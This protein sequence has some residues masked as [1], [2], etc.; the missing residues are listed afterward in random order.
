MPNWCSNTITITADKDTINALWETL[1]NN[2]DD[3]GEGAQPM[4]LLPMP[5][6]LE[7]TQSPVPKPGP[8]DPNGVLRAFVDDETN[9]HWTEA[10]YADRKAEHERLTNKAAEALAETGYSEWYS[11]CTDNWG[12]K[13]PMNV[14]NYELLSATEISVRGDTAWGPPTELLRKVSEIHPGV[15]IYNTFYEEGADFVGA[16]IYRMG[17]EWESDGSISDNLPEDW[18]GFE[19]DDDADAYYTLL[20]ALIDK[21]EVAVLEA[22]QQSTQFMN[23]RIA[24]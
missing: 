2:N 17:T 9:H 11:W 7:G 8:F 10:Y 23:E 3:G 14:S 6:V 19:Y 12:T 15:T 4:R 22:A 16:S 13:W 5:S 24:R 20:D 1:L 21:H 18:G